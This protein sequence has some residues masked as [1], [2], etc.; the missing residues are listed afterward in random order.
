MASE[1]TLE[2][3]RVSDAAEAAGPGR[4]AVAEFDKGVPQ[5]LNQSFARYDQQITINN[6]QLGCLLGMILMPAG[7]VLDFFTYP[8]S[9]EVIWAFFQLRV[10]CSILIGIFWLFV[11]TDFGR[12]QYRTLGITLALIPAL[13]ISLL[14]AREEGAASHYYAGLNLVLGVGG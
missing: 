8:E 1:L 2:A 13:F 9:P 14:I 12:K 4:A 11:R 3:P 5:E 10:W 6:I 7:V